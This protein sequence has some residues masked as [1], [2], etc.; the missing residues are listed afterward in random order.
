MISA[1]LALI[2]GCGAL[3]G[4]CSSKTT[5]V[6][7]Q[8][9]PV[10]APA[11]AGVSNAPVATSTAAAACPSAS[12]KAGLPALTEQAVRDLL[13]ARHAAEKAADPAS[14]AGLYAAQFVGLR[15]TH[16]G[17]T[18]L[19]RQAWLNA[20]LP[21]A[22]T[23]TTPHIAL[24]ATGARITFDSAH[25]TAT[26]DEL[27]VI[28]TSG[29]PRIAWQ[30]P[31]RNA[32]SAL[33]DGAVW[34]ADDHGVVLS[35]APAAGWA[36]GAVSKGEG[37]TATRAV[38]V[39]KLP[40]ALRNLLGRTLRVLGTSGTVCEARLQ[41]FVV[42]AQITPDP[43]TAEIWEGC[44]DEHPSDPA[45]I[46][47]DIWQLAGD[48]GRLLV[49]EF[50]TPCRGA[51]LAEPDDAPARAIVGPE[52]ASP[53]LGAAAQDAFRK[54]PEY[55]E[56]Q[57][58]FASAGTGARAWDDVEARRGVW[59]LRLPGHPTQVFVS[60]EVGTGC[61]GFSA[62]LS[63]LW[64]VRGADSAP[65]LSLLAVP[66]SEDDRRLTPRAL[67]E[68]DGEAPALLFGPDGLFLARSVLRQV[69]TEYRRSLLTSVPFF[70][71]PC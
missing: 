17:L 63:A 31:P 49:G 36:T 18:R 4:A 62:S 3:A 40:K 66:S 44:A 60:V 59:S 64:Q 56:I 15:Q 1:R 13:T 41:R 42:Q 71:G 7:R 65:E 6:T 58:R 48:E 67:V 22:G 35:A 52:L 30:A 68:L 25:G 9:T 16:R 46:A 20:P 57:S 26:A 27:F 10:T 45:T 19:D 5:H 21:A 51:L 32:P 50:S 54:L 55:A 61:A 47:K 2:A 43:R 69:K 23:E 24:A 39:E 33:S 29:G 28:P 70:A 8:S 34:P 14:Y 11:S 12:A 38:V 37:N 53:E